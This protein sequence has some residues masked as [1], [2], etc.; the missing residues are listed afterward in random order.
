LGAADNQEDELNPRIPI[1][2]LSFDEILGAGTELDDAS[3]KEILS[4][5][6]EDV[7]DAPVC[8]G[9]IQVGKVK[10]SRVDE[11]GE[12]IAVYIQWGDNIDVAV[13]L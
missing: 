11:R 13:R 10:E 7:I 3:R 9:S 6:A 5:W 8:V 1:L 4:T 12:R 2:F